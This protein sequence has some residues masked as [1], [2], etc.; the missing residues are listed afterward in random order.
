VKEQGGPVEIVY[1][2]EGTPIISSPN[3]VFKAAPNPNA[4][5]LFQNYC[6]SA[7]CQQ[8]VVDFGGMRSFH[9]QVK[10]KAGR[11][12]LSDIRLM[13]EDAAAVEKLGEEI[14]VHYTKIF[15]V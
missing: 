3:A 14:K 5:R 8:L 7:E 1:A 11:L 9:A 15:R 10:D 13:K 12:P 2:T 4:A 6:F